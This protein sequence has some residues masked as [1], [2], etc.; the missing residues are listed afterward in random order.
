MIHQR[1]KIVGEMS[2]IEKY[3]YY[4]GLHGEIPRTSVRAEDNE[5]DNRA[6][7]ELKK[8]SYYKNAETEEI[9]RCNVVNESG[10]GKN[11]VIRLSVTGKK[12]LKWFDEDLYNFYCE[13]H[14]SNLSNYERNLDRSFRMA[15]VL[16]MLHSA[17][18]KVDS[19][20]HP[21]ISN[22]KID[23]NLLGE[24]NNDVLYYRKKDLPILQA[25]EIE[26]EKLE[27][28]KT[29]FSRICGMVLANNLA[30][31]VYN[32]RT[33]AMKWNNAGELKMKNALGRLLVINRIKGSTT[34]LE[35]SLLFGEDYGL[36][37]KAMNPKLRFPWP[38]I[39]RIIGREAHIIQAH[40][41]Y[42]NY[43]CKMY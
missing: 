39:V 14:K 35:Q 37:I 28:R 17:G 18:C 20:N 30:Y 8:L 31:A 27:M 9:Y 41:R 10:S 1:N 38:F 22:E 13:E 23:K 5:N 36:A 26:A 2:A 40:K 25:H 29:M 34:S 43:F 4:I 6:I 11:S 19:Y 24:F 7:R 3:L 15:E 33:K 12:I 42:F 32:T 21:E 16:I